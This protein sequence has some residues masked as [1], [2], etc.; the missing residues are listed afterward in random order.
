MR[1]ETGGRPLKKR[2]TINR[3]RKTT[4]RIF[5]IPAAVPAMPEKPRTAAMIAM[6]KNVNAQLNMVKLLSIAA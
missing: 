2:E 1:H 6:I 4:N 5:A 3:M